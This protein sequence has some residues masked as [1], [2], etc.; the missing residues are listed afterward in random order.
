M[1]RRINRLPQKMKKDGRYNAYFT[2]QK[3]QHHLAHCPISPAHMSAVEPDTADMLAAEMIAGMIVVAGI[4]IAVAVR[5]P[6]DVMPGL[7][8]LDADA[9][10]MM[11]EGCLDEPVVR[12]NDIV[13]ERDV[14]G[15]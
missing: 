3:D 9:W 8:I 13:D 1:A 12:Q 15:R 4:A 14:R 11:R 5:A 10:G 6:D 2:N 7:D